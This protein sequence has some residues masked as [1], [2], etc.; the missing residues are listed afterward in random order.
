MT[1]FGDITEPIS[2]TAWEDWD[3]ITEEPDLPELQWQQ[4]VGVLKE[5]E[6]LT[7]LEG[8]YLSDIVATQTQY[9]LEYVNSIK[10]ANLMLSK[11]GKNLICFIKDY[12]LVLSSNIVELLKPYLSVSNNVISI[13][14]KPLAEYQ[15][16]EYYNQECLFRT[17]HTSKPSKFTKFNFPK[18]EQPNLISGV[19]AGVI[20]LREHL[21][22]SGT[23]VISYIEYP[24]DYQIEEI[25]V[26]LKQ[27]DIIQTGNGKP[28][29]ILNSNLYI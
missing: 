26:L 6:M 21:G 16:S 4:D 11:S 29:N 9:K 24:E 23:A 12:R 25:Q 22:Q 1:T 2:R 3:E 13:Q 8:K 19:S 7:I 18:L 20:S 10:E 15:S 28:S 27:L 14:T 17:I 5:I